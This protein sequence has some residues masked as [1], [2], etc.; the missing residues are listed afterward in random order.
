MTDFAIGDRCTVVDRGVVDWSTDDFDDEWYYFRTE[1]WLDERLSK[2]SSQLKDLSLGPDSL[3]AS[4]NGARAVIVDES[5]SSPGGPP[6]FLVELECG[7]QIILDS[8]QLIPLSP[9]ELL[10]YEAEESNV[11]A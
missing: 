3:T 7:S 9:L 1:G 5:V 4:V 11:L 2:T 6:Y 8:D 10:A